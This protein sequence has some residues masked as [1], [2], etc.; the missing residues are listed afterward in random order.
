M[1]KRCAMSSIN[2]RSNLV[3]AAS[4]LSF[5]GITGDGS[6]P[7]AF[8]PEIASTTASIERLTRSRSP[9][10]SARETTKTCFSLSLF[11]RAVRSQRSTPGH[12]SSVP[13]SSSILSFKTVEVSRRKRPGSISLGRS[14]SLP[15]TRS[16]TLIRHAP[17]VVDPEIAPVGTEWVLRPIH[18]LPTT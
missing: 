11:P 1:L 4:S 12:H 13:A 17:Y 14:T 6:P 18:T 2:C 10:R 15:R 16:K 3:N 5:P 7:A 9:S 8:S